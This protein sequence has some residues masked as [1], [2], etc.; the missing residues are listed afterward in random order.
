MARLLSVNVGKPREIEWR[1][2]MVY[3]SVWREAV[4]GRRPMR[5][6]HPPMQATVQGRLQIGAH[7]G[8]KKRTWLPGHRSVLPR[9]GH[10]DSR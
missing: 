4:E 9:S 1:E 5:V 2:K 10:G 3:T 8:A 6:T 7:E